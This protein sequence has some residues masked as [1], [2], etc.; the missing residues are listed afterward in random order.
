MKELIKIN[1][2]KL[3]FRFGQ[4]IEDPRDG[5]MLFGPLDEGKPYGIRA[6]VIGTPEGIVRFTNWVEKITKP[7]QDIVESKQS[8]EARPLFLGF[9]TIFRTPWMPKPTVQLQVLMDDILGCVYLDDQYQRVYKTVDLY[10]SKIIKAVNEDDVQ[11]D[12]WFVMV[13]DEVY[14]YCRPKSFVER[15][16]R[17]HSTST[18]TLRRAKTLKKQMSF[19]TED[20]TEKTQPYYYELNFHNQ[21]KARLLQSKAL[22]Q[23]IRESTIAPEDFPDKFDRPARNM[24]TMQASVAWNISTAVFYKCGGRPWKIS[25]IREGVCYVGIV[26]KQMPNNSDAR[27]AC[28]AAQMFLDSGDGVVFKGNVGPWYNPVE[29]DYHLDKLSAR[30]LVQ[31]AVDSYKD[32]VGKPPTELFLH[33]RVEFDDD[34]WSGF[35]QAVE[36]ETNLVGIRIR[37]SSDIKL[38][39]KAKLPVMRGTVYKYSRRKA[40]LWTKGYVP[41]LQTYPGREVPN[42]LEI[43]ITRGI[44]D[45]DVVLSDIL[46]L[47]KLNY[48]ACIFAD[49]V[50]VTLRFADAVGEIL[51]AGPIE[52]NVPL[53]FKH[54]I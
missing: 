16:L 39:R 45:F 22:T 38:F 11:V 23:I 2:P 14:Q 32:K 18:M 34:E 17:I 54:Y 5:L 28:C 9:E 27:N 3:L 6:G 7:V 4:E 50:P 13:P 52:G 30:L 51:T 44:A 42:P 47:T 29:G 33:G 15:D 35:Q 46:A 31:Q 40:Y 36:Q 19:L 41:R 43:F 20:Q 21:L 53:P 1:E 24:H 12:I 25:G 48:N 37:Q 10:A 8:K 26:F 49:G